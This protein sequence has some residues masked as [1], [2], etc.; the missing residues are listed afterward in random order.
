MASQPLKGKEIKIPGPDHAISIVP[1]RGQV[2][3]VVAGKIVAESERALQLDEARY[4]PVFYIPR[5]DG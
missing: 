3:V 1:L 4:P 5:E 2:Q